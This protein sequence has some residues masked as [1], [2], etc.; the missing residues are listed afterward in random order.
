M[1]FLDFITEAGHISDR[2]Q[3]PGDDVAMAVEYARLV[4]KEPDLRKWSADQQKTIVGFQ[5][6]TSDGALLHASVSEL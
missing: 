1:L 2:V 6:R 4:L 3:L 5:V